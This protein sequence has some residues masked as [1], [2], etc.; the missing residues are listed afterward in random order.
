MIPRMLGTFVRET[1][2]RLALLKEAIAAGD[3]AGMRLQSHTIKGSALNLDAKR[4]VE[5][6]AFIEKQSTA[7]ST[8]GIAAAAA[9]LEVEFARVK[10]FLAPHMAPQA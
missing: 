8:D 5:L 6:S 3:F 4:L 7:Q 1:T 2:N 9:E 10:E